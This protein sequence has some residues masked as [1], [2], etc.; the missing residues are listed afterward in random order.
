MFPGP[1]ARLLVVSSAL[2]VLRAVAA[3]PALARSQAEMTYL[4]PALAM[5][6]S[7]PAWMRVLSRRA[8]TSL[9]AG[10]V[11]L[12]TL[13]ASVV[14]PHVYDSPSMAVYVIDGTLTAFAAVVLVGE[15]QSVLLRPVRR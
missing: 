11:L 7:T 4:L 6:F 15:N 3:V 5:A 2:A 14:R 8:A 13:L 12:W 9:A 10:A 1:L